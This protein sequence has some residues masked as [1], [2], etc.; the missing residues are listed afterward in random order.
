MLGGSSFC[1]DDCLGMGASY[2]DGRSQLISDL[3]PQEGPSF[4]SLLLLEDKQ[5]LGGEDCN[6]PILAHS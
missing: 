2:G 5:H 1:M 3:M 6:I 4:L